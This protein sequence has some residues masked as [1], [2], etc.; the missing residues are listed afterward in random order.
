MAVSVD[1]HAVVVSLRA[2]DGVYAP[3][4]TAGD[5]VAAGHGPDQRACTLNA[6]GAGADHSAVAGAAGRTARTAGSAAAVSR[7]AAAGIAG[8]IAGV[9]V[10]AVVGVIFA[11]GDLLILLVQGSHKGAQLSSSR[12]SGRL[13]DLVFLDGL[14]DILFQLLQKLVCLGDKPFQ[15][16]LFLFQFRLLC[17]KPGLFLFVLRLD[18]LVGLA[19]GYVLV[20]QLSVL[21]HDL[22]D[23]V[24]AGEKLG[25]AGGVE[26]QGQDVVAPVFLHGADPGAVAP[27]L[28]I[29][30]G[31][32]RLDLFPLLGD[33]F[34]IHVDLLKN[35]IQLLPGILVALVQGGLLFQNAGLLFLELVD[36][37]LA[38]LTLGHQLVLFAL[39]LVDVGLGDKGVGAGG[40]HADDQRHQHQHDH[41][42]GD[43]GNYFLVVHKVSLN[44]HPLCIS[45]V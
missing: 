9:A 11:V 3:A 21:L 16:R 43:D 20:L 6:L 23:V 29:L 7:T 5:G 12:R 28:L 1:I 34:G 33:H 2:G 44:K 42:H 19:G 4:K 18:G 39:G 22:A 10:S 14:F 37:F 30:F 13:G 31:F 38:C 41:D 17:F 32:G 24:K 27:E 26:D 45:D 36:L 15:L 25:E 8:G 40:D 35:D